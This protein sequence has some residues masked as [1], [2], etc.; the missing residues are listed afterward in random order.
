MFAR[1]ELVAFAVTAVLVA[2]T[3]QGYAGLCSLIS[4][5]VFY[6]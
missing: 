1:L 6:H 4:T 3:C 2:S 5:P